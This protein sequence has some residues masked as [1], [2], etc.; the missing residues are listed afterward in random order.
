MGRCITTESEDGL[1][2]TD[3]PFSS[4]G[5]TL[6]G[7]LK[8]PGVVLKKGPW[9]AA[10]DAILVDYV[11]KHGEGNWNAVQKHSGLSRCGKSCRLRW[12]NHLRPNLK[13]GA[14]TP[15]EERLIIELHAKMGNKWAQMAAHLPGRTDNEIKNYWNTRIKRR[16]RAGLPLYPPD[17]PLHAHPENQQQFSSPGIFGDNVCHDIMHSSGYGTPNNMLDNYDILPY[18]PE[19]HGISDRISK[20]NVFG[21]PCE[22]LPFERSLTEG[23]INKMP[24]SLG[25]SFT[26]G[27]DPTKKPFPFGAK[28]D[29]HHTSNVIFSAS[30]PISGAQKLELPSLQYQQISFGLWDPTLESMDPI[31]HSPP[32]SLSGPFYSSNCPIPGSSGLLEDL[33]YEAKALSNQSSDWSVSSNYSHGNS[34]A[35]KKC[36]TEVKDYLDPGSPLGNS[37]GL[38][39]DDYTPTG[40]IGSSLQDTMSACDVKSEVLNGSWILASESEKFQNNLECC[41]PDAILGSFGSWMGPNEKQQNCPM[42]L[43]DGVL[44]GDNRWANRGLKSSSSWNNMPPVR[45]VSD[46]SSILPDF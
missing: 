20:G 30:K 37:M 42:L 9:T 19:F 25:L 6:S 45:Q 32:L 38:I 16:Q 34:S 3:S 21:T 43:T 5:D 41:R 23:L 40:D 2:S 44:A 1:F 8:G 13:K 35:F 39:S 27:P 17:M 31:V 28:Q 18:A 4:D 22:A 24:Q 11:K 14:F 46:S 7:S 12:A 26:C 29:I 36:S 33:L 10:E 15:E